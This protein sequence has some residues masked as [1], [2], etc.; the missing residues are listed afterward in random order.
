LFVEVSAATVDVLVTV[1][2]VRPEVVRPEVV[3]PEVV[4]LRSTTEGVLSVLVGVL[5]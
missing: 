4:A 2:V 3:R 5:G 1:T